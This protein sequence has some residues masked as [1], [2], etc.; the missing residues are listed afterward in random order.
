MDKELRQPNHQQAAVI[1]A[2]GLNSRNWLVKS[3]DGEKLTIVYKYGK[4]EKELDKKINIWERSEEPCHIMGE[5][6]SI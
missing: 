5:P 1:F 6:V 4:S 3:D 2:N